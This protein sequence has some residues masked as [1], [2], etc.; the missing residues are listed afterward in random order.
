[1]KKIFFSIFIFVL[2]NTI[3]SQENK[4]N[5][6]KTKTEEKT[7]ITITE[8]DPIQVAKMLI[9]KKERIVLAKK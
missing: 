3:W 8:E 7:I 1:M 9:Q 6:E 5:S 2:S 4:I